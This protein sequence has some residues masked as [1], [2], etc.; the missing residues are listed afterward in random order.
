MECYLAIKKN[1]IVPFAATW[2]QLDTLIRSEASH[3]EED[4]YH[5]ILLIYESKIRHKGTYLQN[6]ERLTDMENRGEGGERKQW[7]GLGV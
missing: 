6:R 2:M 1:D 7:D 4:K 5:M 3:E